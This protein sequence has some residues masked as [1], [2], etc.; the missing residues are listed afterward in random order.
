MGQR[1]LQSHGSTQRVADQFCPGGRQAVVLRDRLS[2]L[3]I[4]V[5]VIWGA[6]D[7][8][9]PASQAQGLPDNVRTEI[10]P[11]TGHMVH[12]EAATKVN[13]LIQSFWDSL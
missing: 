3:P 9:L 6:D 5:M 11:A 2:R 1:E 4:P 8:I 7:R 12:M 10:F 13:R